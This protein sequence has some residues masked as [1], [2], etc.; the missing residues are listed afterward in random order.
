MV[1]SI[2][3]RA[4]RCGQHAAPPGAQPNP[5]AS[6]SRLNRRSRCAQPAMPA[7]IQEEWAGTNFDTL[8]TI[9]DEVT[10]EDMRNAARQVL[11]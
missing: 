6:R 10:P 3:V 9:Y 2:R 5:G 8:Q 7:K 1:F 11:A 4:R